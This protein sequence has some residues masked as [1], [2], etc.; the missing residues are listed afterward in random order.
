MRGDPRHPGESLLE[1]WFTALGLS[2]AEAAVWL[3]V[4]AETLKAVCECA[5]PITPELAVR[6]DRVFGG[7]DETWLAL[8]A[9]YS[10]ARARERLAQVELTP[11]PVISRSVLADVAD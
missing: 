5:A 1:D 10:L 4:E 7:G 6:I 11:Y 9:G 2:V 3:G 8:Q